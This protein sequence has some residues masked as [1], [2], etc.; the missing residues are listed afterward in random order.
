MISIYCARGMTGRS[1]KEVYHEARKERLYLEKHGFKVLDPVSEEG[2][3]PRNRK[4]Q[5]T[6][7]QLIGFWKR[8]KEMIREA[9]IIFDMTPWLKSEGVTHEIGYARYHLW[10]PV[11]RVYGREK[12]P[13]A[14]SVAYFEDDVLA[15]DIDHAVYKAEQLFGTQYKRL[16]WRL[17][18][19]NRCVLKAW[20]HKLQEWIK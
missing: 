14:G 16:K 4:I 12:R 20:W 17:S 13:S 6:Y 18:L 3:R 19:Y 7:K 15:K 5:S 8:D 1:M 11:F 10:K 2:V 9:N